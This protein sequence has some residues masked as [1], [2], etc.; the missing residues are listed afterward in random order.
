M[1]YDNLYGPFKTLCSHG[2]NEMVNLI[3]LAERFVFLR[4]LGTV[5][6]SK[7]KKKN[8][9]HMPTY[10]ASGTGTTVWS[11]SF[12]AS[13]AIS[14]SCNIVLMKNGDHYSGSLV[15]DYWAKVKRVCLDQKFKLVFFFPFIHSTL[16]HQFHASCI[17]F[18]QLIRINT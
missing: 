3:L 1:F 4:H 13:R 7:K 16:V 5:H 6:K 15:I 14:P 9:P 17:T 11:R 2:L 12:T 8:N 18:A 10:R